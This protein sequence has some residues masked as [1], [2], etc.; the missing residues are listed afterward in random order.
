MDFCKIWH[1]NH[2]IHLTFIL[3]ISLTIISTW[4]IQMSE[5][6]EALVPL[7]IGS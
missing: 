4:E 7:S 2:A 6:A 1:V 3:F 5:V